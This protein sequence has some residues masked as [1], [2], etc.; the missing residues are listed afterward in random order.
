MVHARVVRAYEQVTA[1]G[2]P[3]TLLFHESVKHWLGDP[4]STPTMNPR[5]IGST[6]KAS[7]L[8]IAKWLKLSFAS[9]TFNSTLNIKYRHSLML[10]RSVP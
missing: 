3:A 6:S 8:S 2:T 5:F 9:L 4:I 7:F 1:Q 10:P